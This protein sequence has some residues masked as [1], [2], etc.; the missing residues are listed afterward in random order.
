MNT[1]NYLR[2]FS[3]SI[4]I[5]V[6]LQCA[7]TKTEEVRNFDEYFKRGQQL[8]GKKRWDRA[9]EAFTMLLI[10]SPGGELADDAQYYMGECYFNKK[11]Y[12]LAISEY[13]QLVERYT[14]SPLVE[15][16][17]YKIAL[18][19]FLLSPKYSRDQENTYKALIQLQDFIDTF[20]GSRHRPEIEQKIETLRA[21]LARK[22]F[23]SG[24]LYRKLEEWEPAIVYLDN[25]LEKYYDTEW[26]V[27]A[28]IEKAYCL[29][30]LR[31]FDEYQALVGAIDFS[32]A[33]LTARRIW[34]E[35]AYARM[36]RQLKKEQA[37]QT[38]S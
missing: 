7:G 11:E 4:L 38:K 16:G 31:R 8:F 17:Y 5:I 21:K 34:L 23:E 12:L 22:L 33:T 28:K 24:R 36:Q 6:G 27:Q 19:Y 35:Q 2:L 32:A 14:Y 29:I 13:Q 18:S 37:R 10:N 20:P 15:D 26:A 9:I 25:M 1:I 30:Q 3:L